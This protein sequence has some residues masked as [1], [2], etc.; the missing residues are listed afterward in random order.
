MSSV[1]AIRGA[2]SVDNDR[3]EEIRPAIK[4]LWT[5][6]I[7]RNNIADESLISVIVA[8]T[9]DLHSMF[10]G[11]ALREECGLDDVPLLGTVDATVVDG[12]TRTIRLMVHV[13]TDVKRSDIK[14][15]Y[16][17]N[18]AGLRPDLSEGS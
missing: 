16:L 5:E 7:Q 9:D 4:E 18:A 11:Q 1:R 6:L 2:T 10:A 3:P 8:V 14:H 17:R 12:M 13:N 15:V